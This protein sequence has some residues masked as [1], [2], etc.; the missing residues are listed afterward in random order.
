MLSLANWISR[1]SRAECGGFVLAKHAFL[2]Y[3]NYC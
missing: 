2:P 3:N 1:H